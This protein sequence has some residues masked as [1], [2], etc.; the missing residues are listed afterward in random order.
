M[1]GWVGMLS[2]SNVPGTT[3]IIFDDDDVVL[4][5]IIIFDDEESE[6]RVPTTYSY[7]QR[8]NK[9]RVL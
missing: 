3:V 7:A 2:S 6:E 1:L 4:S 9:P 8:S 5:H